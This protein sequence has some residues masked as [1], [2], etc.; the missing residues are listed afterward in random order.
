MGT[1]RIASEEEIQDST[2]RGKGDANAFFGSQKGL[3]WKTTWKRGVRST[4]Q[5]TAICWPIIWSLQF[6]SNAE[7]YCRRKCCWCMTMHVHTRPATLSKPLIMWVSVLEH[8]AYSPD[9]A[10]S[11]Y[12][13]FGPLKNALR[14]R[15]FSTDKDVRE[16]VHNCLRY[17]PKT[18]LEGILKFLDRWNKCIEK[19]WDYVEKWRT[20]SSLHLCKLEK[21]ECG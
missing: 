3:Y 8:A 11:D 14:G 10:P 19:E 17:Q 20:C 7:A 5:D 9:L 13:L 1:P 16:G 12:H 4:G 21:Q 2:F 6:A 18:F 15:R